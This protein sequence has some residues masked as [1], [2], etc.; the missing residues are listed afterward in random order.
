[1]TKGAWLVPGVSLRV[2]WDIPTRIQQWCPFMP[3]SVPANCRHCCT[4]LA[5]SGGL[6]IG[7]TN[8]GSSNDQKRCVGLPHFRRDGL[9]ARHMPSNCPR[10]RRAGWPACSE[11]IVGVQCKS[12]RKVK[13]NKD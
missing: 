6:V 2:Q 9:A 4:P 12:P 1:M 10:T 13:P 3:P 11:W 7:H 8:E 5:P